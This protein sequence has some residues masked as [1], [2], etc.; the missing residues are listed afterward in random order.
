MMIL[1]VLLN[2][3]SIAR[4][5]NYF[6]N[7]YGKFSHF[8]IIFRAIILDAFILNQVWLWSFNLN[9]INILLEMMVAQYLYQETSVI[10]FDIFIL[11]SENVVIWDS[12]RC[13]ARICTK[14]PHLS[15]YELRLGW[16]LFDNLGTDTSC[17]SKYTWA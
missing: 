9:N 1:Y 13:Y 15:Q 3:I 8:V 14:F 17:K 4:F 12:K 11:H 16:H 6:T 10:T 2:P 5:R 7:G